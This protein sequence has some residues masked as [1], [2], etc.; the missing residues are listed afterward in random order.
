[1]VDIN[2]QERQSFS[3]DYWVEAVAFSP[4]GKTIL[5]GC[6]NGTA[7]LW[8]PPN[9]KTLQTINIQS[10]GGTSVRAVTF[11]SDGHTLLIGSGDLE[12]NNGAATLWDLS[13]NNLKTFTRRDG[14]INAVA[15]S[16][17]GETV[18]TGNKFGI[19]LWDLAGNE[20]QAFTDQSENVSTAAFSPDSPDLF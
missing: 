7:K 10:D 6:T 14:E 15:F 17:D 8:Q 11:S 9:G 20:K 13:G 16:P 18:L 12:G 1:M 3:H 2:G 4:D 5:T 19:K